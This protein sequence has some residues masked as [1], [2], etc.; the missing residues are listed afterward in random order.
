M[1]RQAQHERNINRLHRSPEGSLSNGR[2]VML[3][4][5]ETI[6]LWQQINKASSKAGHNL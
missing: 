3:T 4:F 6:M 1:L 5:Y 2:R